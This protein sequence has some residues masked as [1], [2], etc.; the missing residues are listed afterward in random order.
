MSRVNLFNLRNSD[1]G[2]VIFAE[3]GID[4]RTIS[5]NG[6]V[7]NECEICGLQ[8]VLYFRHIPLNEDG[9]GVCSYLRLTCPHCRTMKDVYLDRATKDVRTAIEKAYEAYD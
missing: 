9:C 5:E 6:R 2:I 8:S 7:V 1:D 4:E 3:A